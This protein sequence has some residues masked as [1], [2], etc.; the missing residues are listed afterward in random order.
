ML[1]Q[2]RLAE[3]ET[4]TPDYTLVNIETSFL[5]KETQL[6][7]LGSLRIFLQGRNL[8]NEEAHIHTSYLKD[9]APLPGRALVVG[10][11]G[12]F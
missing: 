5:I 2:N 8:L 4:K 6:S 12:E 7:G 1:A 9:Y 11:R 10:I 3:L